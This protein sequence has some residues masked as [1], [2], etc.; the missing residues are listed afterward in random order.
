LAS[1]TKTT[2]PFDRGRRF[3]EKQDAILRTAA[4]LFGERGFANVALDDV[5]RSLSIVKP[6]LYYY[7]QNKEQILYE[8]YSRAFDAA[9]AA[10]KAV[11]TTPGSGRERVE[12][13]LRD[14][15]LAH[16]LGSAPAMPAHD[17]KALSAPLRAKIERRRRVRRNQLRDLIKAGIADGS[18]VRCDPPIVVAAWA[19]A[20]SWI[21]ESFQPRGGLS[22]EETTDQVVNLFMRGLSP[23]TAR[24][25]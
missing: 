5:A 6:V 13:Y 12:R 21:I 17:M 8:C 11:L 16:L 23:A 3:R 14:Y 9:D 1:L 22:A 19:G 24:R 15:L 2:S 7:F 18:I 25:Q 20:A 4:R 10:M